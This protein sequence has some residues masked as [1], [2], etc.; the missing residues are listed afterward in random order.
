MAG[1]IDATRR[2]AAVGVDSGPHLAAALGKPGVAIFGPTD[3][4]RNGP[5][6][7]T[8][9]VLRAPDATTSYGRETEIAAAMRAI[10]PGQAAAA[11]RRALTGAGV[12][13]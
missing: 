3:P 10:T 7:G 13:D 4:A 2:P 5:Y 1:L 9:A 11:L 6:G 12:A 8:I